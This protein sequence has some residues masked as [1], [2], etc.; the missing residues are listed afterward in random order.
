MRLRVPI[1]IG[2]INE[3]Y[4][5]L[6]NNV[7]GDDC[8]LRADISRCF[9][10]NDV[11]FDITIDNTNINTGMSSDDISNTITQQFIGEL[12]LTGPRMAYTDQYSVNHF[13][14][15][16]IP[17]R[18]TT[19]RYITDYIGLNTTAAGAAME[20]SINR[21]ASGGNLTTGTLFTCGGTDIDVRNGRFILGGGGYAAE[22][23]INSGSILRAFN[24][25]SQI[26]V[27]PA[28]KFLVNNLGLIEIR[29]GSEL[30]L[31]SGEIIVRSGGTL[32]IRSGATVNINGSSK[33]TVQAGGYICMESGAIMNFSQQSELYVD[34]SAIIGTNPILALPPGACETNLGCANLTGGNP[35]ITATPF[36]P[37]PVSPAINLPT[38]NST[39]LRAGEAGLSFDGI[40]DFVDADDLGTFPDKG[41]IT[42]WMNPSVVENFRNPFSTANLN[43]GI[44]FE[45]SHTPPFG[46]V[47]IFGDE[48]GFG[49]QWQRHVY[50]DVNQ[51]Q[52]N[53]WYHVII[54]WDKTLSKVA[55]YINGIRKFEEGQSVWPLTLPRIHIGRGFDFNPNR[56]FK[57]QM[58]DVGIYNKYI[59]PSEVVAAMSGRLPS[60]VIGYWD[61]NEGTGL[62]TADNSGNGFT[63]ILANGTSWVSS[64]PAA[65]YTWSPATDLSS[66]T[67]KLVTANPSTSTTYT[68]TA[69]AAG[70][71]TSTANIQ[72]NVGAFRFGTQN[73][74]QDISE[75]SNV[76]AYP[77][78]AFGSVTVNVPGGSYKVEILD[79]QGRV[80]NEHSS[81][82]ET[83]NI[84]VS[85][86][87]AGLYLLQ[88]IQNGVISRRKLEIIH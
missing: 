45:E 40:D 71:C 19:R 35:N 14:T 65:T 13:T 43:G 78:P 76:S 80:L 60:N 74:T 72:V 5:V 79:I 22:I 41:A 34:A 69:T 23:E 75:E 21:G 39:V 29:S 20:L 36:V 54:T 62:T 50:L 82:E 26:T 27:N 38:G 52:A 46:F 2:N 25:L 4:T 77:N 48:T 3:Y 15:L 64:I 88:V 49:G 8:Q 87:N 11:V 83:M 56:Y 51:M 30:T 86:L 1:P 10:E 61:F 66:S 84:N 12:L 67:G 33:I 63:G 7:I 17:I 57:G 9:R 6:L 85:D 32:F 47:V 16:N 68:V 18:S 70:Y 31:E 59:S 81:Q 55:G 58:D 73:L 37:L 53:N 24:N 28:S 44:R 42:F